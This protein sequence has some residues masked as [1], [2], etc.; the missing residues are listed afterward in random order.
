MHLLILSLWQKSRENTKIHEN[1][2]NLILTEYDISCDLFDICRRFSSILE[3]VVKEFA[4]RQQVSSP[5]I[6]QLPLS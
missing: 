5:F 2:E 6:N 1:K 4:D 3:Q